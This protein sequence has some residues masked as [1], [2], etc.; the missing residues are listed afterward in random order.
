MVVL[1]C[2][3]R[4]NNIESDMY[5]TISITFRLLCLT[6]TCTFS[7]VYLQSVLW[8]ITV[9]CILLS[10][11]NGALVIAYCMKGR[12]QREAEVFNKLDE[13]EPQVI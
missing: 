11:L 13:D 5:N 9:G 2:A 12:R 4:I 10:L 1:A 8:I 3:Q 6:C 7:L